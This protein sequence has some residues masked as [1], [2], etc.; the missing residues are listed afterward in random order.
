LQVQ[1]KGDV[2]LPGT[3]G[4][5]DAIH[6]RAVTTQ[7]APQIAVIPET[8]Q[9]VSRAVAFAHRFDLPVAVQGTGHGVPIACDEGMLINTS[10]MQRVSIFPEHSMARVE[11]GATW[12]HVIPLAA[13][14]GLA[15][16]SGSSSGVGVVGYT[17]G[18][19]YGWLTRKYGRA[20]DRMVAAD[21]VT[22]TGSL[23]H[24]SDDSHPDLFWA[25]RGGS[26]NF[27][28]VTAMEFELVPVDEVFGGSV[29]YPLS[30][31]PQVFDAYSRWSET[32]P[33][34]IT[35]SITI[36]RMPPIP[37][38]PPPMRGAQMVVIRACAVGELRAAEESIAPM[39]ALGTPIM[40]TFGVM[41]FTSIDAISMD[42][43]E[44]MPVA[45]TTMTLSSLDDRTIEALLS[46]AGPGVDTPLVAIEI[47]DFRRRGTK[48]TAI[49][50]GSFEGFSMFAVGPTISPDAAQ[51]VTS[52][53]AMM[54]EAMRP[55]AG[56][57][58]LLNFLGE[59]DF[60]PDRTRAAF[61]HDDFARLQDVKLR[62]DPENRFRFNHNISPA[63]GE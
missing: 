1:I 7:H 2:Y 56:K 59:N 52:A 44:S 6:A 46:V 58:V 38:L 43:K 53:L 18:G 54:H 17:I 49:G 57:R 9:D 8:A 10:R 29:M 12:Q 19:G 21:V 55:Y 39:R 37:T 22:A 62:Y 31:A 32:L 14:H 16:L 5:T 60:G 40:D 47:R 45:S 63:M 50:A 30:H 3:E 34:D 24:V 13:A 23:L 20:A 27:G 51:S 25:I 11:A 28:I 48:D 42:P 35:S 15:P 26:G 4:F 61:S 36:L 33:D 41:P